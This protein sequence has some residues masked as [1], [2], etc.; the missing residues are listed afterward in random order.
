MP[1]NPTYWTFKEKVRVQREL[2]QQINS[3]NC[4]VMMSTLYDICVIMTG[5]YFSGVSQRGDGEEWMEQQRPISCSYT[6]SGAC[7][8]LTLTLN[9]FTNMSFYTLFCHYGSGFNFSC[10][11]WP[12][13]V[14][15]NLSLVLSDHS[16]NAAHTRPC[17]NHWWIWT[18]TLFWSPF[19]WSACSTLE[20]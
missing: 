18:S 1:L 3:K 2:W 11:M 13:C 4:K 16:I 8:T 7:M 12:T 9:L 5:N 6:P 19:G 20:I 10:T 14:N 15:S 17:N